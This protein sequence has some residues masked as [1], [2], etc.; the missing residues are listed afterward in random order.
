MGGEGTLGRRRRCENEAGRRRE[1]RSDGGEPMLQGH[2]NEIRGA[3]LFP[4]P[5]SL[6][7]LQRD[8]LACRLGVANTKTCH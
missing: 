2:R 5:P 4:S 6:G 3:C 7:L 1:R 8:K